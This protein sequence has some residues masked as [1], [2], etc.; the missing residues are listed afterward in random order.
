MPQAFH[1]AG[2]ANLISCLIQT[3]ENRGGKAEGTYWKYKQKNLGFTALVST[4]R[5]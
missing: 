3:Q 5:F 1:L 2:K 4:S